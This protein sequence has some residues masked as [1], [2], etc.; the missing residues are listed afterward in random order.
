MKRKSAGPGLENSSGALDQV[1]DGLRNTVPQRTKL[2]I[3]CLRN[4]F[5]LES[6]YQTYADGSRVVIQVDVEWRNIDRR[7]S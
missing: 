3:C 5:G 6:S 1:T 4:L 7:S 2:S